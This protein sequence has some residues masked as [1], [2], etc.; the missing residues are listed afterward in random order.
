MPKSIRIAII[1]PLFI[2]AMLGVTCLH[3][4]INA[5][6]ITGKAEERTPSFFDFGDFDYSKKLLRLYDEN[7]LLNVKSYPVLRRLVA[8]RIAREMESQWVAQWGDRTRDFPKWLEAH[9]ELLE[10]FFI[11]LNEQY[12]DIGN[13]FKLLKKMGTEHPEL[14]ERNPELAIAIAVV[15]DREDNRIFG[16]CGALHYRAIPPKEPKC[17]AMDNFLYYSSEAAPFHA[18]LKLLPYDFLTYIVCNPVSKEDRKWVWKH[19]GKKKTMLGMSYEDPPF[20]VE[21]NDV[22][23]SGVYATTLIGIPYTLE[24]IRK[25]GTVCSGRADYAAAV[26]RSVGVP[27]FHCWGFGHYWVK[28]VEFDQVTPKKITFTI[29]DAGWRLKE[30]KDFIAHT[31]SP[32]TGREENDTDFT[33]YLARAARDLT[34]YRHSELLTRCYNHIANDL[35]LPLEK[36]L[37]L[38]LKINAMSPSNVKV[39]EKIARFGSAHGSKN[40]FQKQHIKQVKKLFAQ[41]IDEFMYAPNA[42]PGL[43]MEMLDFPDLEKDDKGKTKKEMLLSLFEKL[44]AKNRPDLIFETAIVYSQQLDRRER[45]EEQFQL[46]APLLLKYYDERIHAEKVLNRLENIAEKDAEHFGEKLLVLYRTYLTKLTQ[47]PPEKGREV[48][49]PFQ[50][51]TLDRA[52]KVFERSKRNDLVLMVDNTKAKIEKDK[53]QGEADF[54]RWIDEK[55]KENPYIKIGVT[56]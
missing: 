46:L 24:N 28:W 15:W 30:D 12:D 54:S 25:R 9:P 49:Q 27:I 16:D 7:K 50:L 29:K 18:R 17:D 53:K 1:S 44:D 34:A 36:R 43:A 40:Q 52:K 37:D 19:Y 14:V 55:Q 13:C 10:T 20:V 3:I 2:S 26:C 47:N 31:I 23:K 6:E 45:Y 8:K 48:P 33:L 32:Q 41:M 39:W 4:S 38:L 22:T 35:D 5:S 11:A 51:S 56:K 42:L 21:H